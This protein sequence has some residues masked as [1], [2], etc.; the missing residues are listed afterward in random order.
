LGSRLIAD[1]LDAAD[2]ERTFA[3]EPMESKNCF[4]NVAN[5]LTPRSTKATSQS[6]GLLAGRVPSNSAPAARLLRPK[7]FLERRL[8]IRSKPRAASARHSAIRIGFAD[9]FRARLSDFGCGSLAEAL[10]LAGRRKEG[11]RGRERA[12]VE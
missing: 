6:R 3:G 8:L 1:L 2:A 11:P 5:F 12:K 10:G 9:R 7:Q 4:G